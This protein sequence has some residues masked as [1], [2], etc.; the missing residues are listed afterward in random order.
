MQEAD[1]NPT[2]PQIWIKPNND[3][4]MKLFY[5]IEKLDLISNAESKVE[6]I[7]AIY[8]NYTQNTY[9]VERVHGFILHRYEVCKSLYQKLSSD[10]ENR[11]NHFASEMEMLQPF[12]DSYQSVIDTIN[13]AYNMVHLND[14]NPQSC[15][16]LSVDI[17]T[18][19]DT[20]YHY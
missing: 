15:D 5:E 20:P 9:R 16:S 18:A 6:A 7:D 14:D 11:G 3:G 13:T 12:L 10:G 1:I 19:P 8:H 17:S 2:D 4:L